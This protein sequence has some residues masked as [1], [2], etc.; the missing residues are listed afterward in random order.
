MSRKNAFRDITHDINDN[1]TCFFQACIWFF[2]ICICY[3]FLFP[4]DSLFLVYKFIA[5]L[6][7]KKSFGKTPELKC[8]F[9]TQT[10]IFVTGQRSK[11]SAAQPKD[12]IL[13]HPS[14]RKTSSEAL[15]ESCERLPSIIPRPKSTW[16]PRLTSLHPSS[17][18]LTDQIFSWREL[19]CKKSWARIW[20]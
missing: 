5:L 13:R 10:A 12:D 20:E 1:C 19:V 7:K 15:A 9:L 8:R 11:L 6:N 18:T 17:T 16:M 4:A 2:F 3:Y 14:T